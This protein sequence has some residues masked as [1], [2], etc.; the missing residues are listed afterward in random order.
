MPKCFTK[1]QDIYNINPELKKHIGFSVYYLLDGLTS[2]RG[3]L[4]DARVIDTCCS[5]FTAKKFSLPENWK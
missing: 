2:N 3:R 4:Y 1:N 5:L